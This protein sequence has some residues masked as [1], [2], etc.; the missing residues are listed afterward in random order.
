MILEDWT[1]IAMEKDRAGKFFHSH[2][3]DRILFPTPLTFMMM[4][5]FLQKNLSRPWISRADGVTA[6]KRRVQ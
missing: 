5:N 6:R 3:R 2:S 1:K 4:S